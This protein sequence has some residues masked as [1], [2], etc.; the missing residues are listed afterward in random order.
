MPPT[1]QPEF[2]TLIDRHQGVIHK[3]CRLYGRR[4]EEQ[5]LFQEILYQLW[6]SFPTFRAESGFTTWM[7]RIAIN[8]AITRLRQHLRQPVR[9]PLESAAVSIAATVPDRDDRTAALHAAI[10]KLSA[11]DRALI[12]LHLED[13][14]YQEISQ[15]LGITESNVGAKLTRVRAK[16]HDLLAGRPSQEAAR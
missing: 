4:G 7:Y 6:K 9:E 12:L 11:G 5:D 3:V 8:T 13:L 10:R 1:P 16:L 15:V 2:L 14:S